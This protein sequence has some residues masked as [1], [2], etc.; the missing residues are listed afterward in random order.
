MRLQKIIENKEHTLRKLLKEIEQYDKKI[1]SSVR[2]HIKGSECFKR[3]KHIMEQMNTHTEKELL[4]NQQFRKNCY[5][6]LLKTIKEIYAKNSKSESNMETVGERIKECSKK[7]ADLKSRKKNSVRRL[8]EEENTL[9]KTIPSLKLHCSNKPSVLYQRKIIKSKHQGSCFRNDTSKKQFKKMSI[10]PTTY[11]E[12]NVKINKKSKNPLELK[13]TKTFVTSLDKYCVKPSRL[14]PKSTSTSKDSFKAI[15]IPRRYSEQY[16]NRSL[17]N[18]NL[19]GQIFQYQVHSSMQNMR[20]G[21]EERLNYLTAN[22]RN[23]VML[24]HTKNSSYAKKLDNVIKN[25]VQ[26]TD[27]H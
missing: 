20:S 16:H 8:K 10:N 25:L 9:N 15:N 18:N 3:I 23:A 11:E 14:Q 5:K 27:K 17:N 1:P 22:V 12:P 4:K 13:K 19:F 21:Q 24:G 26:L 2:E 6:Y 7:L